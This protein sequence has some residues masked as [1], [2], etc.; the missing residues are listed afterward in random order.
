MTY[1]EFRDW[2]SYH[3]AKFPGL[4]RWLAGFPQEATDQAP[5][6]SDVMAAWYRSLKK[7]DATSAKEATDQ[8]GS[9]EYPEPRGW[10]RHPIVV[11]NI[12]RGDRRQQA[13]TEPRLRPIPRVVDGHSVYRCQVCRDTGAITVWHPRTMQASRDG[14]LRREAGIGRL[15][16]CSV[17]CAACDTP[18]VCRRED[19]LVFDPVRMLRAPSL[20][21]GDEALA[22]LEDFVACR[23]ETKHAWTP[24]S[25]FAR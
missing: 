21:N 14:T 1:E 9:D 10:E 13:R 19:G 8:L 15:Y 7:C 4:L 3:A 22:E 23:E 18:S 11:A 5:S 17:A 16:T 2:L 20:L 24:D 12:C 6:Q 25:A